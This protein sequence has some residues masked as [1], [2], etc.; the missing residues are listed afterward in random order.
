MK[1]RVPFASATVPC[2]NEDWERMGNPFSKSYLAM[3]GS[4]SL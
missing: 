2:F 4:D 1:P 3:A